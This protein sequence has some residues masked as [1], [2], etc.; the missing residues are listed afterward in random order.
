MKTTEFQCCLCGDSHMIKLEAYDKK[1]TKFGCEN[2]ST[3]NYIDISS[4]EH[5]D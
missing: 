2:C 4:F 5:I 1:L 3:I